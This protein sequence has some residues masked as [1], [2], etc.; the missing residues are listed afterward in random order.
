LQDKNSYEKFQIVTE[1]VPK[2]AVASC[3]PTTWKTDF[4]VVL[5]RCQVGFYSCDQIGVNFVLWAILVL[6]SFFF[7]NLPKFIFI[8]TTICQNIHTFSLRISLAKSSYG[9][10][11]GR[12]LVIIGRF[13]GHNVWS[14]SGLEC[15]CAVGVFVSGFV[16]FNRQ[17]SK[18]QHS[19][20]KKIDSKVVKRSSNF[21]FKFYSTVS[22]DFR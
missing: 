15:D 21:N 14:H 1:K 19:Q 3:A 4:S 7:K 8:L 10:H 12:L 11:F 2:T 20:T 16:L 17:K 13:I 22:F 18:F 5:R 9:A 6:G